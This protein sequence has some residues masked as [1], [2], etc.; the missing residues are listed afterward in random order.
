MPVELVIAPEASK[1]LLPADEIA[2][3]ASRGENI[4]GYF[5][6]KFTVV[7]SISGSRH[8]Q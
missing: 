1:R 2:A 5:T 4:S 3:K 6:N 7:K 8:A